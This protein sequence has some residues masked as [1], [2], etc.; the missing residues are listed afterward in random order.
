MDSNSVGH[1]NINKIVFANEAFMH[2]HMWHKQTKQKGIGVEC[3]PGLL[4][5]VGSTKAG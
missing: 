3:T 5:R 2:L 1:S 4:E